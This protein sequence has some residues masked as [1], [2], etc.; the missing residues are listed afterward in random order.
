MGPC[1]PV[2]CVP[3]DLTYFCCEISSTRG[4]IAYLSHIFIEL[5][6]FNNQRLRKMMGTVINLDDQNCLY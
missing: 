2:P 4:N 3:H 6:Y 1:S 5:S